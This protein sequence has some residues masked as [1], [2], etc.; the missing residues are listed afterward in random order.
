MTSAEPSPAPAGLVVRAHPAPRL[1]AAVLACGFL[2]VGVAEGAVGAYLFSALSAAALLSGLRPL[3]TFDGRT[4]TVRAMMTGAR[5][6]TA[7]AGERFSTNGRAVFLLGGNGTR[8]VLYDRDAPG[9][10]DTPRNKDWAALCRS[11][12]TGRTA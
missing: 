7:A 3:I 2:W 1:I 6:H 4:F 12:A 8:R 5:T 9:R 11:I 10:L